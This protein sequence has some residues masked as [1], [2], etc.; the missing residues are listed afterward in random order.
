MTKRIF[1]G[2][3]LIDAFKS[4]ITCFVTIL[5]LSPFLLSAQ[6][7]TA[8]ILKDVKVISSSL[9]KVQTITPVQNITAA[10]F[11]R[12]S[13]F[14]VADAVRNF[15]GV[16]IR[17]YGGIGGLKTISVR[18]LGANHTGIQFD[19][20][21]VTDSQNG[22]VDLG[23]ISL[24]N[25]EAISLYNGQPDEI[26]LPARSF[27]SASIL[28]IRSIRPNL[29]QD[30]P[31]SISMGMKTGS[32]GLFNP[33]L[34][35][36]Q[37][38]NN[39][40][41]FSVSGNYQ[42]ANGRYKY[43]VEGDGSDTLATRSNA[44]LSAIQSDAS[45]FW[46]KSDSNRLHIRMNYYYS[47]RGLPGAVVYYNPYSSQ[48]LWNRDLFI[49]SGYDK[50]WKSGLHL[51]LNGKYSR[52]YLRYLDPEYL[53]TAGELDQRYTQTE[54]YQS[55]ALAFNPV[56]KLEVS[57]SSDFNLNKLNA[58]LYNYSYPTRYT[59]LNV[60]AAR[61]NTGTVSIQGN[62]LNTHIQEQVKNG[63]SAPSR[64]VWSPSLSATFT[65]AGSSGLMLRAFYK[66]IF[67]NP[68]FNDL[69][70]T[71]IG[72][73]SLNP[74]FAKQVNL[75]VTY[76]KAFPHRLNYITFT[77]DVYYNSVKDKIIAIPTKDLF[78]WTMLNL[79]KVDIR[80]LDAGLKTM[81][82]ID[83]EIRFSV[84][85][86]YTFQEAVDVTNRSSS[87]YLD[88]IPYTPKHTL[89][90]NGGLRNSRFGLYYN[91]IISSSRYY[92]S[93]NLPQN[94]VPGFAVADVSAV[95][96]F[97]TGRLPVNLSAE[98]NNIFDRSY[99]F[100]RSFPMPGRSVRFSFQITI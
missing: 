86:N 95:Y 98:F 14:N 19:G 63:A 49:Q 37:R 25:V 27:A 36:Q 88:Q 20:I 76:N 70:Y 43:K 6:T 50:K 69:Y 18:S 52:N 13:A 87:V 42:Q 90:L 58:N 23:K 12:Y 99:A 29:G 10:D 97:K 54:Y 64:T 32:F 94:Y 93:E 80:G 91:Q 31:Y 67:R 15:S 47:D 57:W 11:K 24:E 28:V 89:A 77:T 5:F 62:I 45:V 2:W 48:H 82:T 78:T 44:D 66:D 79:G 74:E 96:N 68:T 83:K 65:P 8:L 26:C 30:K 81:L 56:K 21:Q 73:R 55:A 71:R 41:S 100:I 59:Y 9:P 60:L 72:S 39:R 46:S 7:D 53:N 34:L 3:Y 75:G 22:Q 61:L 1:T 85:G 35:W 84:S 33:S 38:I 17:D 16:N 51:L 92:L 4:I 40:W